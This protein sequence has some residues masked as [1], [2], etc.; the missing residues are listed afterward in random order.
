MNMKKLPR[1]IIRI[2]AFWVLIV[3][4]CLRPLLTV[5]LIVVGFHRF[6]HLALEP[7]LFLART[8]EKRR[9][10]GVLDLWS[11]GNSSNQTNRFLAQ[12]WS[13]RV[14]AAPSWVVDALVTVGDRF[15]RLACEKPKLSIHGPG[16]DLI[17]QVRT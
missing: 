14:H 8:E 2:N 3:I 4:R 7:E 5:R 10:Q 11:L 1:A 6:G 13:E 17:G 15:P 12:K 9:Q 16:M